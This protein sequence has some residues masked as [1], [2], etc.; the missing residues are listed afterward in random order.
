MGDPRRERPPDVYGHLINV[1]KHLNVKLPAIGG[2]LPNADADNHLLVVSTCYNGQCKQ[3]PCFRWSFQHKIVRSAHT[4]L[5]PTVRSNLRAA[6][7]D[8]KQYV[9]SR[10]NACVMI[11][12]IVASQ[13]IWLH[14]FTT[15]RRKSH[16]F[17]IKPT[18]SK[19]RTL[20]S[21]DQCTSC[22]GL[23]VVLVRPNANSTYQ[24]KQSGHKGP[25]WPS[26]I[27]R[28]AGLM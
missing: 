28:A 7:F 26:A 15:S 20:L 25:S 8:R 22:R 4:N 5:R 24:I 12:V 21:F 10:V 9:I 2:H 27:R 3:K 1:P 19:K 11:H 18:M 6:I 23:A 17:C 16:V 13:T 14:L